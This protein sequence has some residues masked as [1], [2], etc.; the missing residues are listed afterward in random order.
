[1]KKMILFYCAVLS[2]FILVPTASHA[3]EERSTSLGTGLPTSNEVYQREDLTPTPTK[4]PSTDYDFIDDDEDE[5]LMEDDALS[6]DDNSEETTSNNSDDSID[7]EVNSA[8]KPQEASSKKTTGITTDTTASAKQ[9]TTNTEV[10]QNNLDVLPQTGVQNNYLGLIGGLF[11]G[12]AVLL[13]LFF[14]LRK[15]KEKEIERRRP[16]KEKL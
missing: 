6:N 2:I 14:I 12:I 5:E 9:T 15:R 10:A 16:K 7:D 13:L 4:E 3:A 8:V 1:M 11:I